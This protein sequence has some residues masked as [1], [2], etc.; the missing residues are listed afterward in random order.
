MNTAGSR[1]AYPDFPKGVIL[2]ALIDAKTGLILFTL[3]LKTVELLDR[4]RQ[5]YNDG[6]LAKLMSQT[7][8]T[9]ELK[10]K[11]ELSSIE[12]TLNLK[13]QDKDIESHCEKTAEA[14]RTEVDGEESRTGKR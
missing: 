10:A 12:F 7:F 5:E 8:V 1:L 6:S 11:Y 13:I 9:E 4:F 14:E 3:S 2:D